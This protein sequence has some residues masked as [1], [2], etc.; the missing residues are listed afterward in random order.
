MK[1]TRVI[2]LVL[3]AAIMMMGAGYAYWS[4]TLVINNTVTTGELEVVFQGSSVTTDAT[5]VA[6]IS[7]PTASNNNKSIAILATNMYPGATY[8]L[9][10]TI[11]NT[12]TIPAVLK[13]ITFADQVDASLVG[14]TQI[15]TVADKAHF[16]VTGNVVY[17]GVPYAVPAGV[18]LANISQ[19]NSL[20]PQTLGV[21][22]SALVNLT[23]TLDSGLL[24]DQL[25]NRYVKTNM[26]LNWTQQND[27]A[28]FVQ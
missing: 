28:R 1:R 4:D 10:T 7:L 25:E 9:T 17:N 13:P 26:T 20:L 21:G 11:A 18:T 3:C 22:E 24:L 6:N 14:K 16:I 2:A 23:L 8:T 27:P 12:G 19:I 5:N 15:L